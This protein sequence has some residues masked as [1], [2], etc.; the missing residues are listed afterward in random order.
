VHRVNVIDLNRHVGLWFG[1]SGLLH[2]RDLSRWIARR[3]ERDNPIHFHSHIEAQNF[4]VELSAL[5]N[6]IAGDI[7]YNSSD[8]H[9]ITFLSAVESRDII[10]AP[11][12]PQTQPRVLAD[13]SGSWLGG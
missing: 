7:R 2:E 9:L 11:N 6:P 10:I 13:A 5:M 4:R 12:E 3:G 8:A 1:R